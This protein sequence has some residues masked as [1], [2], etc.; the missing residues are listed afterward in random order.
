MGRRTWSRLLSL[1]LSPFCL[2]TGGTYSPPIG[3]GYDRS[4]RIS[5][6]NSVSE[7]VGNIESNLVLIPVVDTQEQP[8]VAIR[9]CRREAEMGQRDRNFAAIGCYE[10]RVS[11][12]AQSA[13]RT[14]YT[15]ATRTPERPTRIPG[16]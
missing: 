14:R 12:G 3:V 9:Q 4:G 2:L 8:E 10:M 15:P 13:S 5:T 1:G 7:G 11:D 16:Q 6:G